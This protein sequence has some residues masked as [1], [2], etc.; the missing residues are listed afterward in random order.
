MATRS[1][2][3]FLRTYGRYRQDGAHHPQ[4]AGAFILAL[5]LVF[6]LSA[7]RAELDAAMTRMLAELGANC[8]WCAI[9]PY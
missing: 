2:Q 3:Q 9:T 1:L 7:H 8:T 6:S 4:R 5:L